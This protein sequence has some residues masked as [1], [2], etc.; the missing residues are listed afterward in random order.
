MPA[1]LPG[2]Y[3]PPQRRGRTLITC[4]GVVIGGALDAARQQAANSAPFQAPL[5]DG[6]HERAVDAATGAAAL[7]L[8]IALLVGS[9]AGGIALWNSTSQYLA[10]LGAMTSGES[11]VLA[12]VTAGALAPIAALAHALLNP[13]KDQK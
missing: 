13:A 10:A 5:L 3:A 9:V 1:R 8:V 11:A 6:P 2:T 7:A 12:A 4:T